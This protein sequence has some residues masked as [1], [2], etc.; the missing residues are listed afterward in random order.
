MTADIGIV[1]SSNFRR[2]L[3]AQ[4]RQKNGFTLSTQ[5]LP[6]SRQEVNGDVR[7][8]LLV[9]LK[10]GVAF[11][12]ALLGQIREGTSPRHVTAKIISVADI[13]RTKCGRIT[14]LAVHDVIMDR[15]VKNKMVLA[16]PE[17]LKLF[18]GLEE[19]RC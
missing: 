17:A 12:D 15:E 1:D 11:D 10:Q 16:K 14:E 8:V 7:I 3:R 9:V 2:Q 4:S 18:R 19:L 5:D 13:P 6:P